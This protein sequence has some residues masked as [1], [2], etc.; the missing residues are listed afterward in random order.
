MKNLVVKV[1]ANYVD[2]KRVNNRVYEATC[3]VNETIALDR[4]F[5]SN[6]ETV[7]SA[8]KELGTVIIRVSGETEKDG[9]TVIEEKNVAILT[10]DGYDVD[11]KEAVTFERFGGKIAKD[12]YNAIDDAISALEE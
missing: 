2:S 3:T 10:K 1:F 5:L 4:R 11:G 8:F 6:L 12:F 9:K 7:T